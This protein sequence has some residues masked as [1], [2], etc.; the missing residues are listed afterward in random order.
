MKTDDLIQIGILAALAYLLWKFWP[1]KASNA[2]G[3]A[4]YD[5]TRAQTIEDG[6]PM[7]TDVGT[8]LDNYQI[9]DVPLETLYVGA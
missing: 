1:G 8:L 3:T 9:S 2:V 7:L 6:A 4:L 5:T